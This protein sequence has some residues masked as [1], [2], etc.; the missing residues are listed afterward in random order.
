[1]KIVPLAAESLGARSMA[2]YV[3]VGRTTILIDPGATLAPSRFNLPP[4]DAEWEALRRANDR[5]SGYAARARVVF[6]SH[7]HED[8]FRYDPG[9]YAGRWVLARDPRRLLGGVQRRRAAELWR[10]IG[11]GA[12]LEAADGREHAEPDCALQ[13]SPPLPHGADGTPLG[14]VVALTI[15]DRAEGFRFVFAGDVQGPLSPVVSAYLIR[16]RPHLLYLSG[17]PSYL[18][19]Q[20][21]TTVIDRGVD[22]LRRVVDATG[23][24]V[25]MDHHALRDGNAAARFAPLWEDG[26]VVTAA[27]YLGMPV[28]ALE[29]KRHILWAAQ[30]KPPARI[31][32]ERAGRRQPPTFQKRAQGG[33][34]G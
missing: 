10:G 18:E 28:S 1:M 21:G 25:I 3:E 23:C 17:P 24:Q 14:Y 7:Y 11:A 19:K 8:H 9:L 4:A 31:A 13:V 12:R 6:V 30:R 15:E 32:S 2:T 5:I 27:G 22:N 26:R 34:H 29:G 20:L 16:A 33:S